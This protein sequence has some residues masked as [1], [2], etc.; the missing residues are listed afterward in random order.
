MTNAC[1]AAR[2]INPS[3]PQHKMPM[4][5]N[6]ASAAPSSWETGFILVPVAMQDRRCHHSYSKPC[7]TKTAAAKEQKP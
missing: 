5:T 6:S 7:T 3:N 1:L 4:T 2:E